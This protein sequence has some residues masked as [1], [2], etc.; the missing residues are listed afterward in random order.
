MNRK[1]INDFRLIPVAAAIL[2]A[3]GNAYADDSTEL[4]NLISKIRPVSELLRLTT[5]AMPSVFRSTPD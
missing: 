1:T 2:L 3:F 5:A 4:H